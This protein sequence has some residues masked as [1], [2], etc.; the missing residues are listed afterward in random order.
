MIFAPPS[1]VEVVSS[2]EKLPDGRSVRQL[3]ID[4]YA[5]K[6]KRNEIDPEPF[7]ITEEEKR[8]VQ[9]MKK[10]PKY[11]TPFYI[12]VM[13]LTRRAFIQ[14]IVRIPKSSSSSF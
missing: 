6:E 4:S 2:Q 12:H 5:E 13:V 1:Q 9:D 3:L 14:R 11:P 8:S 10:G 7:E